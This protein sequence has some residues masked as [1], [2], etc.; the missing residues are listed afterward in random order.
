MSKNKNPKPNHRQN[1]KT[2]RDHFLKCLKSASLCT[3]LTAQ[4]VHALGD[5]NPDVH[6]PKASVGGLKKALNDAIKGL[7]DAKTTLEKHP[8]LWRKAQVIHDQRLARKNAKRQM[9]GRGTAPASKVNKSGFGKG[10]ALEINHLRAR[11]SDR[12]ELDEK[13][14]S[15]LKGCAH[16]KDQKYVAGPPPTRGMLPCP[17][18]NP[19]DGTIPCR[20]YAEDPNICDS[21]GN[22]KGQCRCGW[23]EEEHY[24]RERYMIT[25]LKG[26]KW[27]RFEPNE[28]HAWLETVVRATKFATWREAEKVAKHLK[29]TS[30]VPNLGDCAMIRVRQHE[31]LTVQIVSSPLAVYPSVDRDPD[32][33]RDFRFV[34]VWAYDVFC[35]GKSLQY[36][37]RGK[38]DSYR[39]SRLESDP[40]VLK[41][42]YQEAY[43]VVA[44]LNHESSVV[45]NGPADEHRIVK[46]VDKSRQTEDEDECFS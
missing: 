10:K 44:R 5:K 37:A 31:D 16:C 35:G 21:M 42:S 24:P 12:D 8:E 46:F 6:D 20:H 43:E 33:H 13:G 7:R 38:E 34:I 15:E 40:D 41:F 18:C 26:G 14:M 25:N 28:P 30:Y 22:P 23:R 32:F 11:S 1:E 9:K 4:I 45:N 3:S 27:L 17:V 39:W 2:Y 36:Y 19:A 29:L